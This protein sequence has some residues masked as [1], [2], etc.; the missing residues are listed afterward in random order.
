MAA[1]RPV[2]DWQSRIGGPP[3]DRE[4]G[5]SETV[6]VDD[7]PK[8]RYAKLGRARIAYQVLGD[9]PI[10]LLHC[11]SVGDCTDA[12]WE[13]PPYASFLRRLATFTRL[14]MFDPRG[15]GA[16][17]PV[18]PE[19]LSS[20]EE[21]SDDA[22]AVLDA[23][24]SERAAIHGEADAGPTA[25]LFAATQPE[26]T[27][28]LVL[29]NTTAR[30]L[31]DVD[32]PW[33]LSQADVDTAIA[34]LEQNWGTEELAGFG[35]PDMAG[36]P[37]YVRW[38][39]KQQ[40][41]ACSPM[42]AGAYLRWRQLTDVR[43]VLPSIGVPTLVI[44]RKDV[45][46]ITLDEGRYLADRIPG[47]RL[48][49]VPGADL[50]IHTEQSSEILDHI[51]NFLTGALPSAKP[52]R[53]LAAVL[54]TDIVG[55]TEQAT[56]LGDRQW[57][58]L[59]ESHDAVTRALVSQH[60]GR[61][62]KMTGDGVLATFD[63]PGRAIRCAFALRDTLEP[64]GIAIRAGLHAGEVEFRDDD[65]AGIGVHIAARVLDQAGGGELLA[66]SAV[67]LL[68]AGSG[69][70]FEDRGEHDLKGVGSLRLYAVAG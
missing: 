52:D 37:A 27:G 20:W 9:G 24:G 13:W 47:G 66:S 28:A 19:A 57:R 55:S 68:V 45:G 10:D 58:A 22:R 8:T 6:A 33:G 69:V 54:F 46:F 70:E 32:Y 40:R 21:W 4:S 62:V 14:I 35:S 3:S 48:V 64:L 42:V 39:A 67:P 18:S 60:R 23:V 26:R 5:R 31:T 59:L 30:F 1:G 34:F 25:V 29:A 43:E 7:V 41:M 49:V 17:D 36:D 2:S 11:P 50:S 61:L 15:M 53:A 63:G 44:H 38:R 16:S 51:E 12:R 65:I 56:G